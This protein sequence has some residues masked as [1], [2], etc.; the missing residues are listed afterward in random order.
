M[1]CSKLQRIIDDLSCTVLHGEE[2]TVVRLF[3][4]TEE[5]Q[6]GVVQHANVE[7]C[8]ELLP[9][10]DEMQSMVIVE[11]WGDEEV[12]QDEDQ[13]T[14]HDIVVFDQCSAE[15]RGENGTKVEHAVD[16]GQGGILSSFVEREV[17]I[18]QLLGIGLFETLSNEFVRGRGENPLS[19]EL[20][21]Q[22]GVQ[23]LLEHLRSGLLFPRVS[24]LN[25]DELF[26]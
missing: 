10:G 13:G 22:T 7:V 26:S 11:T 17:E 23:R 15:G 5:E 4:R 3:R 6:I 25:T 12:A 18:V 9:V 20:Q 2:T 16:V 19:F 8:D 21:F 14:L 24:A 1:N